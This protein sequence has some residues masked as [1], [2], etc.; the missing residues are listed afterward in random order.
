MPLTQTM[1]NLFAKYTTTEDSTAEKFGTGTA[2]LHVSSDNTAFN[3]A[4]N[5]LGG[6][7]SVAK[8]MDTGY[9]KRNDGTDSTAVNILA[10]RATYTTSEANF[11]WNSWM[12]KNSSASASGTGTALNIATGAALGT[13]S[14]TQA[15]QL[16]AKITVST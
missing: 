7:A 16:L 12:V 6:T 3:S 1:R 13:K 9:P 8:S 10:Y 11:D 5:G 2:W 14:N 4:N 15:W